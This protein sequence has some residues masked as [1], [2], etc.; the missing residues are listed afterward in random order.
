MVNRYDCLAI[1][2]TSMWCCSGKDWKVMRRKNAA[3]AAGDVES[4]D[5]SQ[6][7]DILES[8][9]KSVTTPSTRQARD[10]RRARTGTRTS[11]N[12]P[13]VFSVYLSSHRNTLRHPWCHLSAMVV[14]AIGTSDNHKQYLWVCPYLT[15]YQISCEFANNGGSICLALQYLPCILLTGVCQKILFGLQS[16]SGRLCMWCAHSLS[17]P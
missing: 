7:D 6:D 13:P 12:L 3:A 11:R 2:W 5:D 10:R 17:P 16:I 4:L 1:E 15:H 8:V 14:N 9:I